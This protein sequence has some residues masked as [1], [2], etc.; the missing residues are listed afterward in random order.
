M[1]GKPGGCCSTLP[2]V[3]SSFSFRTILL[4]W[5][6]SHRCRSMRLL[7]RLPAVKTPLRWAVK[8]SPPFQ[9]GVAACTLHSLSVPSLSLTHAHCLGGSPLYKKKRHSYSSSYVCKVERRHNRHT[10]TRQ[11]LF[12][13]TLAPVFYFD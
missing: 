8:A 9:R 3:G 1:A 5:A 2:K 7:E 13:Q 11:L 10:R 6:S 4:A 12:P